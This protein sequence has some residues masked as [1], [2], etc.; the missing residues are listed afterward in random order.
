MSIKLASH[1]FGV[2]LAILPVGLLITILSHNGAWFAGAIILA[3]EIV[4][5]SILFTIYRARIRK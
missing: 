5:I 1:V 2:A 4:V 3:V